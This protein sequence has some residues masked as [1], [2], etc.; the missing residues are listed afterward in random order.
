[1]WGS[2]AGAIRKDVYLQTVRDAGFSNL[3]VLSAVP[4]EGSPG[5]GDSSVAEVAGRLGIDW[6][7]VEANVSALVSLKLRATK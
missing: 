5:G 1:M 3:E 2:I 6:K 7:V 4:Y